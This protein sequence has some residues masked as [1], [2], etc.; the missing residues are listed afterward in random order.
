MRMLCVVLL[1]AGG[2]G[3]ASKPDSKV[4]TCDPGRCLEDLSR[5]IGEHRAE[6]KACHQRGL[7]RDP[8]MQGSRIVI[9]F[10]VDAEGTVIDA[11]Q[12][13]KGDQIEDPE[14][15]ACVVGVIKAI[16]FPKSRAGKTTRG[17]HSFELSTR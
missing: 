8:K 5:V 4:S 10:E 3:G 14:T 9:N 17:Y 2:C 13:V 6:A 1:V 12:S 7:A 16:K 11:S 15:V